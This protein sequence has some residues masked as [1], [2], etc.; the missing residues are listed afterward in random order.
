MDFAEFIT[1]K[2]D[3]NRRLDKVIR[4]FIPSLPLSSIYKALRKGLIKV[5]NSKCKEDYR[6]KTNDVIQV[7][8]F[9]VK[10]E[11]VT[12]KKEKPQVEL[13]SSLIIFE[14]EHFLILNKPAGINVH[15]TGKNEASLEQLVQDYYNKTRKNDSLSFRPG[16][17]HRI[18]KYTQGLVCFSMSTAGAQWFSK[19]LTE[20]NIKKTY[21]AL[22]EGIVKKQERWT[23]KIQKSQ[24]KTGRDAFHTMQIHN[25]DPINGDS[26]ECITN[27]IPINT[28]KKGEIELTYV[29][30]LIETGRQHQIRAQSAWHGH[31]LYGDTAYGGHKTL[32]NKGNF[33]LV[34]QSLEF[35]PNELGLPQKIE[36]KK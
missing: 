20:H 2:D 9:L 27:V 33:Y 18:D 15:G 24:E 4:I 14:N 22:V 32:D 12:Q 34:A 21:V 16:P 26:K 30:F 1:G 17:L 11:A 29:N 13:D 19:N 8:N 31:P 28:V 25:E 10:Q 36:L 3:V 6:I 5:N 35:P 23:D 7:A